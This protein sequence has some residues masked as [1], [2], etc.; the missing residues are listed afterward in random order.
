MPNGV[1]MKRLEWD[2]KADQ[3]LAKV[4][5]FFPKVVRTRW[6]DRLCYNAE[7]IATYSGT[8]RVSDDIFW[9]AAYEVLPGGYDPLI[10]MWREPERYKGEVQKSINQLNLPPGEEPVTLIRWGEDEEPP[11]QVAKDKRVLAVN[12]SARKGGNTDVLI[13]GI[14]KPLRENGCE[15]EKLY[16]S[17]LTIKPCTGCRVCRMG[18]VKAFCSIKDD[19]TPLYDKLYAMDGFVVGFPIYTSRENGILANFMDRWDCLSNPDLSRKMPRGKKALVICTW[20]WPGPTA[21]DYIVETFVSLYTMRGMDVVDVLTLSG[22]RGKKHG[23][24]VVRDHPDI[25][26][27]VHHAGTNFSHAVTRSG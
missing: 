21:Y 12:S 24:G 25:M 7:K 16:L 4:S 3:A 9:Q 15:V 23:K 22:T 26:K 5:A 14:L 27:Q 20:M 19:M 1:T 17:D 13:D 6:H 18:D 2:T 10:M 11:S 8:Q